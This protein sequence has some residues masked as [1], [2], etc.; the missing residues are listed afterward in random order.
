MK[1]I[2]MALMVLFVIVGCQSKQ[3]SIENAFFSDGLLAVE[4]DGKWGYI[5]NKGK[6]IIPALYDKAGAFYEGEAIVNVGGKAQLI[7]K[8]GKFVLDDY[9]DVLYRDDETKLLI[10]R[11]NGRSGL[12][13]ASGKVLSEALFDSLSPFSEGYAIIKAGTKYGYINTSGKIVISITYDHAR[14]FSN[15]LAAVKQTDNWGYIDKDNDNIITFDYSSAGSFDSFGN[16]IVQTTV[17]NV[18]KYHMITKKQ[19][20]IL[21]DADM[22]RGNGPVYA[23]KKGSDYTLH[24]TDGS[25]FNAQVYTNIWY[26]DAYESNLELGGEDLNVM[27]KTDGTV[28]HSALYND[29]SLQGLLKDNQ[30]IMALVVEDGS[31]IDVKMMDETLRLEADDIIQILKKE[32]YVVFRSNK[33]GVI[34]GDNEIVVEFLYDFMM[35]FGDGYIAFVLNNKIGFMDSAFKTIIPATYDDICP[36]YNIFTI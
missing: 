11:K 12:M 22:I 16:A 23:M 26:I 32:K 33:V 35:L 24:K 18:T 28:M 21:S 25:R 5:N 36:D 14:A 3:S 2:L 19:V 27:F 30:E 6:F 10:Y 1:K 15:G 9:V 34:N 8:D 13:S 20:S 29:S 31:F 7:N 4:L 17:D